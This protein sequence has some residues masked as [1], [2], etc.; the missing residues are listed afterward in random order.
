MS[1]TMATSILGF[2]LTGFR[3]N[4][5]TFSQN[6]SWTS[7]ATVTFSKMT[8]TRYNRHC[9]IQ[10]RHCGG[11]PMVTNLYSSTLIHKPSTIISLH[12]VAFIMYLFKLFH[13]LFYL[14]ISTWQH[15]KTQTDCHQSKAMA[16]F[17][18]FSIQ[19]AMQM[20]VS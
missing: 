19:M 4:C 6:C 16:L 3:I 2:P 10:A 17:L 5:R 15:N 11:V 18:H 7:R 20:T 8:T 1:M 12:K 9:P 14:C 13:T